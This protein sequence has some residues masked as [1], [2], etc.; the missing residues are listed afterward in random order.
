ME[1]GKAGIFEDARTMNELTKK[2]VEDA[3]FRARCE[4]CGIALMS[5]MDPFRGLDL[6]PICPKCHPD[7]F[8]KQLEDL[9]R[10]MHG[11][12]PKR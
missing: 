10:A 6:P 8:N 4:K 1:Q 2:Q 7:E 5:H 9:D 3:T 12:P 11:H